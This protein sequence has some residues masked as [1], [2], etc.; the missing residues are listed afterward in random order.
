MPD[1]PTTLELAQRGSNHDHG[2][3]IG[4]G[5]V[6]TL[7][8]LGLW[9]ISRD[10][11][12]AVQ[13]DSVSL[14]TEE[15]SGEEGC[16]NFGEFWTTGTGV[17]VPIEAIEAISNCRQSADGTWFV[18][19]GLDD[20]RLRPESIL[21]PDQAASAEALNA[22]L[23]EDLFALE[24]A[25]P[26]SLKEALSSNY[27]IENQPV[28]GHTR[29]GR[30]DLTVKRNRY[31]RVTQAFLISPERTAV[32]DYVG[33]VTQR[34]IEAANAFE[35]TCRS[36]PDFGFILRACVG[37]RNEFAVSQIPL[38]WDLNDPV[39]IQEYLIARS[40]EPLVLPQPTVESTT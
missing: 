32:A 14:T 1:P 4:L 2:I 39:L 11:P 18:P 23:S 7:L 5:V 10:S 8:V 12:S 38:Y 40:S 28:F 13:Q 19:I 20:P 6:A 35:T 22:I 3:A 9:L 24:N 16:Q 36:S 33:W 37:I 31:A 26:D 17:N 29:R 25:L 30:T 34:R 21:P 27:D 15:V